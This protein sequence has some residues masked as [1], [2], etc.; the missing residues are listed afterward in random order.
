M[1]EPRFLVPSSSLD[2]PALLALTGARLIGTERALEVTGVGSLEWAS[3]RD[4]VFV[5]DLSGEPD[6]R[7]ALAATDAGLCLVPPSEAGFAP[8][9]AVVLASE[10]PRRAFLAIAAALFPSALRP[11]ALFGPGIAAGA[12]VHPE[13][14]LEPDV[15]VDPGAVIGPG[16]EIGRG[17]VIGANAVLGAGVRIGRDSA[18]GAGAVVVNALIGDR[19]VIQPGASIGHEG[20]DGGAAP[21][22]GRV[23]LQDDVAIGANG[24]VRRGRDRDTVVG[25]GTRVDALARIPRDVVIGRHCLIYG[26]LALE[27][28]ATVPDFSICGLSDEL[29]R[30]PLK[31]VQA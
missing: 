6:R 11:T 18:I 3:P 8:A 29:R 31:D 21:S 26:D 12:A 28:G 16:A 25:E 7:A 14:R 24:A 2:L 4:A 9:T 15:S 30:R 5:E 17:A 13:A 10:H 22:L 1:S 20:T 23:I 19:V 27:E